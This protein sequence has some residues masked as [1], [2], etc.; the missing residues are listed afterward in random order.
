MGSQADL[1]LVMVLLLLQQ[2]KDLHP[3]QTQLQVFPPLQPLLL[4]R[5]QTEEM[6]TAWQKSSINAAWNLGSKMT[7]V[8][9]TQAV[10]RT[11]VS[12]LRKDTLE[13]KSFSLTSI[14]PSRAPF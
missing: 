4:T 3:H 6:S 13:I 10:L 9:H 5:P 11:E 12:S 14:K 2:A 1:V 7:A 8:E